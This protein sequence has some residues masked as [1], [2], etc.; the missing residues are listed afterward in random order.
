VQNLLSARNDRLDSGADHK[1]RGCP[2]AVFENSDSV[3]R[4][5]PLVAHGGA[6]LMIVNW[7]VLELAV[8]T[9]V[10]SATQLKKFPS[11]ADWKLL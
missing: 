2:R 8:M 6:G 7:F 10:T 11:K 9:R 3:S 4:P 1:R 5:A